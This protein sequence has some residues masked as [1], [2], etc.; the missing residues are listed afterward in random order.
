MRYDQHPVKAR[1][2]GKEQ[3]VAVVRVIV[4][5]TLDELRSE[6]G[7]A[8]CVRLILRQHKQDVSNA[9]RADWRDGGGKK[10][11]E[12]KAMASLTPEDWARVAGD[13][14]AIRKLV[15]Q[16]MAEQEQERLEQGE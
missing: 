12:A 7:D 6:F 5:A 1:V 2:G 4:E 3:Q 8:G 11:R 10:A 16:R 9:A 13:A 14:E 15:E